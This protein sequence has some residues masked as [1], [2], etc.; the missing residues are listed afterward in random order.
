MSTSLQQPVTTCSSGNMR[1]L[2]TKRGSRP[3]DLL[4]SGT[5]R[6][7]LKLGACSSP[8]PLLHVTL[9]SPGKGQ[10][11]LIMSYQEA[12]AVVAGGSPRL[13]PAR[14]TPDLPGS[15]PDI[16]CSLVARG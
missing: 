7:G 11:G 16:T 4:L 8:E 1:G 10:L 14:R 5:K 12:E 2:E 15:P 3:G 9:P 13:S 6:S